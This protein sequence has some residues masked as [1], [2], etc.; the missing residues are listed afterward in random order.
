MSSFL[1][2]LPLVA[3]TAPQW[4]E[5]AC[6]HLDEVLR[7]HAWCEFKAA[8]AGL[9]MISRFPDQSFL[10]RPMI[11]L[12]QEE[13]LHFRQVTDLL[14]ERGVEL[15][16][17]I[18]DRYV[19]GLRRVCCTRINGL[20]EI[21][22]HL[23]LNAFVEARSCERFRILGARLQDAGA[24]EE[25]L[26]DFYQRLAEAEA[27]HWE[28]FRDLAHQVCDPDQVNRR[29]EE[30]AQMEATLLEQQPVEARMH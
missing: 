25:G 27:R 28:S 5:V 15:G 16:P 12:A 7:D 22:D 24:K 29:I 23:V 6:A 2:G 4:G 1:E 14:Q 30:V 9:G 21:G 8:S 11:A 10:V 20:G 18:A 13:M 17:P 19:R 3:E 26:A